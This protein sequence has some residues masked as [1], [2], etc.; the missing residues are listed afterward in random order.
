MRVLDDVDVGVLLAAPLVV[1][2][3]TIWNG[4]VGDWKM[5][6]SMYGMPVLPVD[7]GVA[8]VKEIEAEYVGSPRHDENG[9]SRRSGAGTALLE[10]PKFAP[11]RTGDARAFGGVYIFGGPWIGTDRTARGA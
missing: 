9:S 11:A 8:A 6:A 7:K 10:V 4:A 2:A 3:V 5:S 1:E